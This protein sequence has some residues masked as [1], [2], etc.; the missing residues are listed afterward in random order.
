MRVL[1]IDDDPD[2]LDLIAAFLGDAG[3]ETQTTASSRE[4][5]RFLET[6]HFDALITDVLIPELDG[7]EIMRAVRK[8]LP[9]LWIIAMSGGTDRLSA[10]TAL[11]MTQMLGTNR[12]LYKPF[13][14]E[15]LI[16][17]LD[18]SRENTVVAR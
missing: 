9:E 18:R 17:A 11:R 5:L 16:A 1:V 8:K 4:G 13:A 7:I 14:Q 3:H 2:V 6:E 12:I 15:H 10:N